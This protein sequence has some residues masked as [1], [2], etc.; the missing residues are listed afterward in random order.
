MTMG[1]RT[2]PEEV[3]AN[4]LARLNHIVCIERVSLRLISILFLMVFLR[5]NVLH[6]IDTNIN[7][8]RQSDMGI[9]ISDLIESNTL[10]HRESVVCTQAD[11]SVSIEQEGALCT[12]ILFLSI[13]FACNCDGLFLDVTILLNDSLLLPAPFVLLCKHNLY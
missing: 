10:T 12:I 11:V 9:I 13:S 5:E 2:E 8:M 3:R 1:T 7:P 6:D 4:K